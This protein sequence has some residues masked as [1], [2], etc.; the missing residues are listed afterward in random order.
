MIASQVPA[1]TRVLAQLAASTIQKHSLVSHKYSVVLY[2]YKQP[3]VPA[4]M[5]V[6]AD[7]E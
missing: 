2:T 1:P 3:F 5:L 7:M 4:I 6:S